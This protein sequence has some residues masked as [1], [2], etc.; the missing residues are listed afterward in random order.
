M[1]TNLLIDVQRARQ[2]RVTGKNPGC[3]TRAMRGG[4][5]GRMAMSWQDRALLAP[6]Q[7][8]VHG[9][10]ISILVN[11]NLIGR[12]LHIQCAPACAIGHAVVVA[13]HADTAVTADTALLTQ[14]GV[15]A[16]GR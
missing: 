8:S 15:K 9:N 6:L 2:H 14:D 7:Q 13:A 16:P 5:P 10:Q 4:S 12:G 11:A 1:T 3:L